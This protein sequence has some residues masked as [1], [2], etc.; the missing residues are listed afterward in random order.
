M[1]V[2]YMHTLCN[3]NWPALTAIRSVRWPHGGEGGGATGHPTGA[4][5]RGETGGGVKGGLWAGKRSIGLGSETDGDRRPVGDRLTGSG[6]RQ[7]N[8]GTEWEGV[9]YNRG[10]GSYYT[11]YTRTA[12]WGNNYIVESEDGTWRQAAGMRF[13]SR[14]SIFDQDGQGGV[15]A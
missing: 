13:E 7:V 15:E 9:Q 11:A 3:T 12:Y 6:E 1:N 5:N 8:L 2:R 4:G 14:C 10:S